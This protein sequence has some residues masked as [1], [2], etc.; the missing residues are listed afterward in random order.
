MSA[1]TLFL[2][3]Q[4]KA[5]TRQWFPIGRLDADV[6]RGDYRFRYTG[7]AERAQQEAGFPLL[8]DFPDP[9]RDYQASELFPLFGNRVIAQSR[10]ISQTTWPA[11]IYRKGRTPSRF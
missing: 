6:E 10:P 11:S 8:V 4:D 3:W 1:K 9:Q 5:G 2:A 7:G